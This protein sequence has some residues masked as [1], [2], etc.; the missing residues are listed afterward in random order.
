MIKLVTG[1]RF[2]HTEAAVRC[3]GGPV[4]SH[5]VGLVIEVN[6]I[7]YAVNTVKVFSGLLCIFDQKI[8][9]FIIY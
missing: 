5:C 8:S 3:P 2:Y 1:D 4:A 6:S 7:A 9:H